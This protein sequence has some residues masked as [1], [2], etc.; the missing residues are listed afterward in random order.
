[1]SIYL[2]CKSTTI[3]LLLLC[4]SKYIQIYYI[5]KYIYIYI[6]IYIYICRDNNKYI[7]IGRWEKF[8]HCAR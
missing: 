8:F 7:I 2:I 6:N 3:R 1:M 4:S 5:Y